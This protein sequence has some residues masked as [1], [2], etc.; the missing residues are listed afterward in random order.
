MPDMLMTLKFLH[1]LLQRLIPLCAHFLFIFE[2][3][4]KKMKRAGKEHLREE[5]EMAMNFFLCAFAAPSA[6]FLLQIHSFFTQMHKI[7]YKAA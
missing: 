4:N 2:Y 6:S 7:F 5:N 1:L 3:G